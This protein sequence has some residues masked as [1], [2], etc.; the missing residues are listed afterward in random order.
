VAAAREG[1][2]ILYSST[3]CADGTRG[4]LLMVGPPFVITEE[5]LTEAVEK[6]ASALETIRP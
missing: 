2:L 1:G 6:T 5:E 4:D 3:G